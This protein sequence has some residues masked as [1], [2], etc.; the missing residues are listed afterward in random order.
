MQSKLTSKRLIDAFADRIL[1]RI[2]DRDAAQ[3]GEYL[4]AER[5]EGAKVLRAGYHSPNAAAASASGVASLVRNLA[6]GM[7]AGDWDRY[8]TR[9]FLDRV[10]KR[11]VDWS[12]EPCDDARY[13]AVKDARGIIT[14]AIVQLCKEG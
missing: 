14:R 4:R 5:A 11:L 1:A 7:R 8:A 13:M 12:L 6:D 3:E 2:A 9:Q 10:H